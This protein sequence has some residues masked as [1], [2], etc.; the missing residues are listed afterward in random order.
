[1]DSLTQ[2]TLGAAVGELTLGKK[3][4]NKAILWGAVAGTIPDLDIVFSPVLN[5]IE[6]LVYHRG[7]SHALIFA[8]L[9]APILGYLIAKLH[10]NAT[11]NWKDWTKL[12]FWC[13][14]THPLLDS[15]TTWG[16]QLFLPFSDVRVALNTIFVV[17]PLYT[18]PFLCFVIAAMFFHRTAQ[19][20]R[21]VNALGI[22]VSSLYLLIAAGNKLYVNIVFEN[23]LKA[24]GLDYS[25]YITQPTPINIILWNCIAKTDNGF[26]QDNYSLFDKDKNVR[27]KY[28]RS[29]H[30]LLDTISETWEIERFRWVSSGYFTVEKQDGRL[31]LN[32]LRFGQSD[33]GLFGDGE[34]VF[35]YSVSFDESNGNL[36]VLRE[37]R[38]FYSLQKLFP[39]FA[40]RI[41][42]KR[43]DPVDSSMKPD[44]QENID[45]P[46]NSSQ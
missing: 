40:D 8:F 2:I 34:Y 13:L 15:L 1:M 3:V 10:R 11:A 9:C 21:I 38:N 4:G 33:F 30:H 28:I 22:G 25:E 26:W 43:F 5:D 46:V 42:G 12:A 18:L 31:R 19:K 20:R 23:S 35:A 32:D 7:F 6:K 14:L 29:N 24:Q 41:A 39:R 36:Q 27:F 17:D 37:P 45:K 16:T 44:F